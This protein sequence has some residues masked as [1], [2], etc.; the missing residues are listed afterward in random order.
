MRLK[1]IF[2]SLIA[3]NQENF[4]EGRPLIQ[5]VLM[6]HDLL[7][8]YKRKTSARCLMKID[9]RNTYDMI[10]WEF[11]E[12]VLR[13]FDFPESFIKLVMTCVITTK[14]SVKVNGEGH[15]FF[16]GKGGLR[17]GDP[18]SPLLFI[19]VMEYL[20]RVLNKMSMLPDF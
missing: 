16:E 1:G 18:M 6:C 11:I 7:S 5:N 2:S 9:L 14:F 15:G 13:R 20:S 19:I 10:C 4:V 17:K 3:E 12:E 8:C